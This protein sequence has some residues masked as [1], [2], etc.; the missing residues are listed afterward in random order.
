M[1][2]DIFMVELE[3]TLVPPLTEYMECLKRY[4]DAIICFAEMGFVE[5]TVLMQ[6]NS[7]ECEHSVHLRNEE[8]S[9]STI[10]RCFTYKKWK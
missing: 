2:A 9:S 6:L 10:S 4:V 8:K 1:L 7:F 5:C 3:N